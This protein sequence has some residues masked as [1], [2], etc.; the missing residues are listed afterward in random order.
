MQSL[1]EHI[2]EALAV[3]HF[4]PFVEWTQLKEPN[5]YQSKEVERKIKWEMDRAASHWKK[6][7]NKAYRVVRASYART[8]IARIRELSL[9][10]NQP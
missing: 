7:L 3:C 5:Y 4:V 6:A 1:N 2:E 10:E 9:M 8:R